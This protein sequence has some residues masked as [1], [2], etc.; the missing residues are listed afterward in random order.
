MDMVRVKIGMDYVVAN[1]SGSVW[2]LYK[3]SFSCHPLGES[4]QHITLGID[5]H[6]FPEEINFSFVHAKCTAHE[7]GDLWVD[8]LLEKPEGKPWFLV[9][10]FNVILNAE[11]KRGGLPFRHSEG[12]KLVQFMSLADV[13]DAGFSA[14]KFTWCNN[15]QG[16]AR[17]WKRLDRLLIN[18]AAMLMENNILVQYLGRDLSDH[19]PLLLSAATRLDGKPLPFRFL[20]LWTKNPSF[21][22]LVKGSWDA[23]SA[24]SPLRVL[25]DKMRKVKHALQQWSRSEFGDIFLAS[26]TAEQRVLEAEIV[27]DNQPSDGLLLNLQEERA[28]LRRVVVVEEEFWR[29]KAQGKWLSDRDKNTA[30]FHVV[31]MERR[32]KSIIHRIWKTNGEWVEDETSICAEAVSFF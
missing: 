27:H 20:N 30:F 21:L 31:V 18:S 28:K 3:S 8:L 12:M 29:Q 25:S 13:G 23:T 4:D 15:R 19:A 14:S 32:R 6:L 1:Q 5:S 16:L 24:G 7:R 10:D 2:V 17:V 9:G 26:R 11:E 22:E